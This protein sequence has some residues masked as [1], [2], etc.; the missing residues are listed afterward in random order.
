[1]YVVDEFLISGGFSHI[2]HMRILVCACN[3]AAAERVLRFRTFCLF[4]Q[5]VVLVDFQLIIF[6]S[7]FIIVPDFVFVA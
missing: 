3:D 5:A 2:M 1:M 6:T 7:L 4:R